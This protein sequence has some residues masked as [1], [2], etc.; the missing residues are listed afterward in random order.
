MDTLLY[1]SIDYHKSFYIWLVAFG[2]VIS[3]HAACFCY[4]FF[5]MKL[6]CILLAFWFIFW[7]V[8]GCQL[9]SRYDVFYSCFCIYGYGCY[10]IH[11]ILR[12]LF[13]GSFSVIYFTYSSLYR[14]T[15]LISLQMVYKKILKSTTSAVEYFSYLFIV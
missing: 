6:F 10:K 11:F 13:K 1:I 5:L 9:Y 4:M 14:S 3:V 2:D 7:R 12:I 15:L 8:C